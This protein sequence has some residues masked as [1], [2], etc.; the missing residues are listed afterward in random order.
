MFLSKTESKDIVA[1]ICDLKV[2]EDDVV[3]I[4]LA[5]DHSADILSI[6]TELNKRKINFLAVVFFLVLFMVLKNMT[7]AH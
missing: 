6:V 5:E 3:V 1:G 4:M 2:K 7:K